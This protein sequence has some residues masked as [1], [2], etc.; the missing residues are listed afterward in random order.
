M[1]IREGWIIRILARWRIVF[2]LVSGIKLLLMVWAPTY[3]D[4]FNWAGGAKLVLEFLSA[5]RFPAVSATGV[6]GP[7]QLVLSPFF[8]L[9][10]MLP[11]DH[12]S[13][14]FIQGSSH[15]TLS[16]ISLIFLMRLPTLLADI[17]IGVL[18]FKLVRRITSS[19]QKGTVA[20]LLW[21]ANPFNIFWIEVFGGMDVIPTL[22]LVLAVVIGSNREWFKSGLCVAVATV[23]RIFPILTF[24]FFVLAVK[25]G[26][27]RAY[28]FLFSGFL[29]PLIGGL[30]VL[31]ITGAGT[32]VSM[33]NTPL[34]EYWLLDFLGFK[35]TNQFV[36]LVPVLLAIQF[37]VV[38]RY[39][40]D[41]GLIHLV[42]V[43]LLSLLVAHTYGGINHHFIWVVPFLT[44]SVAINHDEYWI[45]IVTFVTASLYPFIFPIPAIPLSSDI[46]HFFDP[47]YAGCFYAAKAAYLIKINFKNIR[48]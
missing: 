9:W 43:S 24:P 30:V 10:I 14:L 27:T 6:Y 18:L 11:V 47:F 17:A 44:A 7:L 45:F 23:L 36:R 3:G 37:Y 42:A 41:P 28:A 40:K 2:A 21:Y 16:A 1:T 8:W 46:I 20:F 31:Y 26:R 33:L 4:L 38:I 34:R 5:G 29:L 15:S 35:L 32:M 22:V 12:P 48:P 19:D 13:I 39:W 25:G